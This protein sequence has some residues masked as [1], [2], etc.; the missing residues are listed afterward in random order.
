RD[1]P[2]DVVGLL[3]VEK[4]EPPADLAPA[5]AAGALRRVQRPCAGEYAQNARFGQRWNQFGA[6]FEQRLDLLR[7]Y[8]EILR[9]GDRD[10][11]RPQ[12]ADRSR[13][14][15]DVRIS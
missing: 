7:R 3:M 12:N 9:A 13:G 15:H 6:E 1:K 11:T 14:D 2:G 10:R 4:C 8:D 5:S